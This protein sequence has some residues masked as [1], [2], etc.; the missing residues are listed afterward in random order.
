M[1]EL[2]GLVVSRNLTIHRE[3]RLEGNLTFVLFAFLPTQFIHLSH[4]PTNKPLNIESSFPGRKIHTIFEAI[5]PSAQK[6]ISSLYCTV[7]FSETT[8]TKFM[9]IEIRISIP[10][11]LPPNGLALCCKLPFSFRF[12]NFHPREERR[13][14]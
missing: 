13:V 12:N 7:A 10:E 14:Y 3:F 2:K 5:Y 1:G 6:Q 11:S 8:F 9:N 4:P